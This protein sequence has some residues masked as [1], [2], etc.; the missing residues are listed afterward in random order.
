MNSFKIITAVLAV[1]LIASL[2]G[3]IY[4]ITQTAPASS[5]DSTR[6]AMVDTLSQIQAKVDAELERMGQS[7]IYASEQLSTTGLTG[8]QA[9]TILAA[10]AANSTFI[11]DAGTQNMTNIMVAVQPAEYNDTLGM[12]VGEQTW[13]N[14][15][16][17][18]DITPMMT[19]VVTMVEG[20]K[21]NAIAAPVFNTDK[22]QIGV[23]SIIFDPQK[24]LTAS[25]EAVTQDTQYE[26]TVMQ[27]NGLILF[28]SHSQTLV[29]FFT[30]TTNTEMLTVGHQIA[31]TSSGYSTYT[32]SDGQA[33]QSYWTTINAYGQEWRLITHHTN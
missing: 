16:P 28:D 32:I 17:N 33:K 27:P 24:L 11:V 10:L 8:P 31:Q 20:F 6:V 18:G 23:V 14:T 7:L 12:Y 21:G 19:P 3:N 13:L 30:E 2:A 5:N 22:L 29:N 25:I 1:A 9:D 15:N 26:F 4:L